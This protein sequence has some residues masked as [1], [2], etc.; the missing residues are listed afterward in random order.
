M[1]HWKWY[2]FNSACGCLCSVPPEVTGAQGLS[3]KSRP[4]SNGGSLVRG[5]MDF[6][7]PGT[8]NHSWLQ[9]LS[10]FLQCHFTSHKSQRPASYKEV[11]GCS[12]ALESEKMRECFSWIPRSPPKWALEFLHAAQNSVLS[13]TGLGQQ[14][15]E[16]CDDGAWKGLWSGDLGHLGS[17]RQG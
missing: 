6:T 16:R 14:P 4:G 15:G 3:R 9:C 1:I 17:E 2:S 10:S 7:Y 12:E 13:I 5:T 11:V 8:A